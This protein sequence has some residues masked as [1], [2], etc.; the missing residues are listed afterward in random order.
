[1]INFYYGEKMKKIL[2]FFLLTPFMC[3]GNNY[4]DF[5]SGI[6]TY[7]GDLEGNS[8]VYTIGYSGNL[9]SG[10]LYE[11]FYSLEDSSIDFGSFGEYDYTASGLSF[12]LGYAF[13]DLKEGSPYL[14]FGITDT[15]VEIEGLAS[16]SD[17]SQ[18][19][20]VG[21]MRRSIEGINWRVGIS[22]NVNDCDDSCTQIDGGATFE[23]SQNVA[24]GFDIHAVEDIS[25][26]EFIVQYRF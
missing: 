16:D 19:L 12:N 11:V 5:S 8:P 3:F 24:L 21:Y 10:F 4:L 15:D 6:A 7:S 23:V 18:Y 1:V 26:V 22:E 17:A 14:T 25:L 9:D 2:L 13:M 20:S